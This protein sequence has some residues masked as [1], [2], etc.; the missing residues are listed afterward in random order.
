MVETET[1]NGRIE[2]GKA[3][4][5]HFVR[6]VD[7]DDDVEAR[8]V[9]SHSSGEV[10]LAVHTPRGERQVRDLADEWGG[11]VSIAWHY[12]DGDRVPTYVSSNDLSLD[13]QFTG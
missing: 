2:R 11:D 12:D 9:I 6:A 4:Q 10:S 1:T 8:V 13:V 5:R 7:N 3:T